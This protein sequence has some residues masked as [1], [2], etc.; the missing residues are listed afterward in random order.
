MPRRPVPG[1]MPKLTKEQKAK[2]RGALGRVFKYVGKRYWLHLII[3]VISIFAAVQCN[4]KGTAFMQT[5]VD[6]YITP[7]VK[8]GSTDF[9]GLAQAIKTIV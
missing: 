9:S 5:L 2:R 4:A 3:V 1:Q 8:S 6:D 7:M